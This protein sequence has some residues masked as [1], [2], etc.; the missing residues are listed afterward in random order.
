MKIDTPNPPSLRKESP[1]PYE[2]PNDLSAPPQ[3]YNNHSTRGDDASA[4]RFNV[5]VEGAPP[6]SNIIPPGASRRSA[7]HGKKSCCCWVW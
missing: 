3:S 2:N 4:E 6:K 1:P 7:A 5:D